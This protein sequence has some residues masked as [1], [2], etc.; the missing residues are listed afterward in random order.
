MITVNVN[1]IEVEVQK[2]TKILHVAKK[3]GFKIPTLCYIQDLPATGNCGVCMVEANGRLVRACST[4]AENGMKIITHTKK[5]MDLRR[6]ALQIILT[7]H[8][9]D[10]PQCIRN[11]NCELQSLSQELGIT[12]LPVHPIARKNTKKDTSSVALTLDPGYCI[13]CGRC[14]QVCNDVQGVHA[15]S[16]S[17]RGFDTF[18][19]PS[20]NRSLNDSE[21]VKC[22]QCA[23]YCPVGAIYEKDATDAVWEALD[24]PDKICVV[25]EAPAV[26]V[27]LGEEFGLEPGTNVVGEMYTALRMLGFN[28]IFDTNFGADLTIM[29]EATELATI[30]KENPNELPLITSCCPSWVDYLEKFYSDLIPHFSTA[31]SPHQMVGTMVKTYWAKKMNISPDKIFLVSVMPCTAKKY[32]IERMEDMYASGH[33]DV[34]IT[35]TTREF[36]RMLK[37]RGIDIKGLPKGK[38]DSPLGE[39]TGAGTIFGTTGGVMEAAIRTAYFLVTGEDMPNPNVEFV[40]GH[41]AIKVGEVEVAGI[42]LRIAVASGLA[43]VAELLDEVRKAKKEGKELP[44]HFI[45]VMACRGG[46]VGGGGQPYVSTNVIRNQRAQGLYQEDSELKYKH[47]HHNPSIKQVYDEFLEKPNSEKAHHLLHTSYIARPIIKR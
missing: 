27:A 4:N 1:G 26:R 11:G 20:Y 32:E 39:Y 37:M 44:Y 25:Q 31:K 28:Y 43:N 13:Q 24:D 33:K 21:C 36:A 38:A 7:N 23:A 42:K 19:G 5:L 9:N 34:D 40:R 29:E 46:C 10:C 17:N 16:Y 15:L 45:E 3:A 12:G 8:P 22:G 14:I 2:D 35:L 30:L 47:S 6:N 18:V 41:K